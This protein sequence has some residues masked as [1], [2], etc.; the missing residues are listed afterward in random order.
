MPNGSWFTDVVGFFGTVITGAVDAITTVVNFIIEIV[1]SVLGWIVSALAFIVEL[2]F[3][4]PVL[5]RILKWI[6]NIVLTVGSVILGLVDFLVGLIGIL[7]EKKLRICVVI[8][9]DE[10][11]DLLATRAS[12]VPLLQNAIDIFRREANVRVIPSAPLQFDSGFAGRE[13]ATE[14]WVHTQTRG[15]NDSSVL[16]VACDSGAAGEDLLTV[17][18]QFELL[19]STACFYSNARRVLGYGAPVVVFIVRSV[20]GT[21]ESGCSLGPL[22]DYVTVEANRPPDSSVIAHELGHACNLLHVDD[23]N[24]LMA[25]GRMDTRLSRL[26]VAWLRISR[27]VTYS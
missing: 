19:A 3:S 15:R 20:G 17:G 2:L 25:L 18:A 8:L 13:R 1:E 10:M 9:R 7:P 27:H 16:D 23:R 4:I 24:N 26:Q 21:D 5:G 12:L 11:G 6:W 22:S 14:D